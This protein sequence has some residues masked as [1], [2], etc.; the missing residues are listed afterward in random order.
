MKYLSVLVTT[1]PSERLFSIAG[2]IV[3]WEID[4][5]I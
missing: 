5:M 1:V 4:S 2:V 3:D